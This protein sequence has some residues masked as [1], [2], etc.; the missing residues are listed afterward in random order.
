MS[1]F[2]DD[3]VLAKPGQQPS[4]LGGLLGDLGVYMA[5]EDVQREAVAKWLQT[6]TPDYWLLHDQ[7]EDRGW[8]HL[9][10]RDAA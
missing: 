6:N 8:L 3:I 5:P 7:L 4:S 2:N 1:R 10:R 9:G